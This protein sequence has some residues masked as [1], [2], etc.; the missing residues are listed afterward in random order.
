[1]TVHILTILTLATIAYIYVNVY[2][3]KP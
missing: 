2:T 3:N 1:M